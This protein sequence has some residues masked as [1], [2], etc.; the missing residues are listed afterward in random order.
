MSQ[1]HQIDSYWKDFG[2]AVV[3][4]LAI[5]LRAL[6][7]YES[8]NALVINSQ[9]QLFKTLSTHFEGSKGAV[10]VQFLECET[11][12]NNNLIGMG[13]QEFSRA[14]ELARMLRA[15]DV[16]E[17][18]FEAGLTADSLRQL[19]DAVSDALH[20]RTEGLPDQV[21]HISLRSLDVGASGSTGAEMIP[22]PAT[23]LA[24]TRTQPLP[25]SSVSIQTAATW[26]PLHAQWASCSRGGPSSG[27]C[28]QAST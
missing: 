9:A 27:T 22:G 6:R 20:K 16:G 25:S 17:L 14:S 5:Y 15:F 10:H 8:N 7:T 12:I 13:F 28:S 3:L 2:T 19:A 18:V 11:F 26:V 24:P 4:E 23:G 21:D 1:Q